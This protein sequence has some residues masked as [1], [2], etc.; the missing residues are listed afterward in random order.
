MSEGGENLD[1][2]RMLNVAS[3]RKLRASGG[4]VQRGL[5]SQNLRPPNMRVQR[6]RS[7]ASPP[8][9]PLTRHPLGDNRKVS[10]ASSRESDSNA[11]QLKQAALE[12]DRLT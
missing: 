12:V 11:L 7:S 4:R 1:P 10:Q 8:R 3:W 5:E 9:S 2:V 6:I